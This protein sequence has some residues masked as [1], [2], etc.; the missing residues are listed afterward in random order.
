VLPP[1]TTAILSP[2]VAPFLWL[3][4]GCYCAATM[5]RLGKFSYSTSGGSRR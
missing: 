4:G 1:P 3:G 2:T 5:S